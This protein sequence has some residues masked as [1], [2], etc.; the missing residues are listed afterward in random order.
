VVPTSYVSYFTATAG[1]AGALIGLLFVAVSFR[2]DSVFGPD[3]PPRGQVLALSSFTALANAFFLS[4]L[5]IVP[6]VSVGYPAVALACASL[7]NTARL[8]RQLRGKDPQYVTLLVSLAA[9]TTELGLGIALLARPHSTGLVNWL[10]YVVV[11]EFVAALSRAWDLVQ[12]VH[13]RAAPPNVHP[14]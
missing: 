13:L 4:I 2:S 14:D 1:A 5:A 10:C 8:H 7:W 11:A 6:D 3:A 12:G 9:Y